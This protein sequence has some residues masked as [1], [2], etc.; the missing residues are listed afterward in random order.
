LATLIETVEIKGHLVQMLN[1][2]YD[3]KHFLKLSH[4]CDDDR[5]NTI[6][7]F[8]TIVEVKHMYRRFSLK[9]KKLNA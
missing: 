7:I 6:N 2:I 4:K 9:H 5:V 8:P 3:Q 1:Q